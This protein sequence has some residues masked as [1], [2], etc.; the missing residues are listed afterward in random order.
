MFCVLKVTERKQSF[1]EKIFGRF[2]KD[3]YSLSTIPVFKGAPFYL[4]EITTGKRGV[5][6]EKV[7]VLV[8]KCASRLVTD[9]K[10]E[11]PSEMNIGKFESD[12][13]Y[14]K[15]M[16]NTFLNILENN[17]NKKTPLSVSVLD[18]KGEFA[19]F[20][21]SVSDYSLSLT[22]ATNEKE[23]YYYTCE[24]IK[25][26]TGLCPVLTTDFADGDIKINMDKNIMTIRR[27]DEIINISSGL[28]LKAPEI[29]EKL[30]PENISACNFYSALYELCGVFA[31]GECVFE[32]IT[33]NNE[34]KHIHDIHFS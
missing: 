7:L 26:N 14:N 9:C 24:K 31:L 6:W 3:E 30:L 25:N 16:K 13:L 27:K 5:D 11:L 34:K 15:V 33:V 19:D 12:R 21:E 4:L 22:I 28:D 10:I 23:K 2:I 29:Y 1:Y 17:V 8:G 20:V 32:T 18:S